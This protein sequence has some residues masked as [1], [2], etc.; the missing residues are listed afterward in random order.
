MFPWTPPGFNKQK[1]RGWG[2]SIFLHVYNY[3][4][5]WYE[6]QD[7]LLLI[8]DLHSFKFGSL[9]LIRQEQKIH[10]LAVVNSFLTASSQAEDTSWCAL[11]EKNNNNLSLLKT[12]WLI[13]RLGFPSPLK[14]LIIW[15][16]IAVLLIL[17]PDH[18]IDAV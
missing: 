18:V 12:K 5:V 16:T 2:W 17:V 10:K 8:C 11:V 14:R 13:D 6:G 9:L 4:S 15:I 3:F 1:L 7:S